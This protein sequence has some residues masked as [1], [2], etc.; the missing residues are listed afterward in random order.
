MPLIPDMTEMIARARAD[1]RMGLGVVL[2][3]ARTED[4][5]ATPTGA[6]VLAAE[7][8]SADRLAAARA[9]GTAAV[10]LTARRAETL[11][12]AAYDGD[13][14]RITLPRD[15]DL[16]WVRAMADPADDLRQPM[17]GPFICQ[18]GGSADLYRAALALAKSARLLPA[19]LVVP[20][21]DPLDLARTSRLTCLPAAD[22]LA[23]ALT[24]S[25]LHPVDRKS[26][27]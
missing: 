8:L 12:A 18:R 4:P 2:T 24:A 16:T 11:K 13:L 15:A 19:A 3:G 20:V 27:V 1:L 6:L 14:A 17:K 23:A 26:V 25:P 21:A 7:T 5:T 10:A 9:L 22:V